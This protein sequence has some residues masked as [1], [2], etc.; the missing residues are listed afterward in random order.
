VH[1]KNILE[2]LELFQLFLILFKI[3]HDAVEYVDCAL[4]LGI[5]QLSV[6]IGVRVISPLVLLTSFD[7]SDVVLVLV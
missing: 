1:T 5:S 7:L 4:D 2:L 6:H 3:E